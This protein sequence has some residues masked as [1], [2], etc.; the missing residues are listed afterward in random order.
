MKIIVNGEAREVA[1]PDLAAALDELGYGDV[2][3]AT[4]INEAFVP[5]TARAARR[6]ADGDIVE[7]LAPMQGG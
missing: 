5:V 7:V 1:G 4:A 6:L 2:V 3:V